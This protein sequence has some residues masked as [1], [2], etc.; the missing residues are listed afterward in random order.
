[1]AKH[2]EM[3]IEDGRFEYAR[4]TEA[5]AREA[6]LDGFYILRTSEPEERL[7][8]PDVVRSYKNLT[9]VERAFRS[10]TTVD[11]QIRPIRHRAER[12]VRAHLF[13]CLLSYYVKWHLRRGLAPLLS[14][15]EDLEAH[16]ARRDPVLPA[17][18]S[19]A[20]KRKKRKRQTEG[21]LPIHSFA[22]LMA[23]LAT[24]ARHLL[25]P[26]TR[27]VRGCNR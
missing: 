12:R 8:K 20:A 7:A 9:N 26:R 14:D 18:L 4:R 5:I 24:Q 13:L 1:M 27:A 16:R 2:F 6:H 17:Q 25:Q 11:L 22:T 15:E 19:A 3:E 10:L 21:G 23:E